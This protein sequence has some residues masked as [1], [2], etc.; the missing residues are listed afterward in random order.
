MNG[1]IET[2]VKWRVLT[3]NTYRYKFYVTLYSEIYVK[4]NGELIEEGDRIID[5]KLADTM[6]RIAA[7]PM[8]FYTGDLA[9]DIVADLAEYGKLQ[10]KTLQK[11]IQ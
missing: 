1:F 4:E 9:A 7:D 6:E 3:V 10:T 2:N 11:L 8:S 5:D